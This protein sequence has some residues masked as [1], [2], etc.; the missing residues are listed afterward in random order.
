MRTLFVA[1]L[2]CGAAGAVQ[3]Q[4]WAVVGTQ[5][6][7]ADAVDQ[8]SIASSGDQKAAWTM[9]VWRQ[10][11][12]AEGISFDYGVHREIFDCFQ[13]RRRT[14]AIHVY[15]FA[16]PTPVYS[17][18]MESEWTSFTP[19]TVGDGLYQAVCAGQRL[20]SDGAV[21]TPDFARAVRRD[22]EQGRYD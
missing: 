18:E 7:Y 12:E 13:G 5:A 22:L 15:S 4:D 10:T 16:L 20:S 6:T 17:G 14:V 8:A 1:L 9:A 19:G 3:A 21:A 11:Q 2:A